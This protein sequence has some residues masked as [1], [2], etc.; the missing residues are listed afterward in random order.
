MTMY[1]VLKLFDNMIISVSVVLFSACYQK[2]VV[3]CT[4]IINRF[5]FYCYNFKPLVLFYG[6]EK[7]LT[8]LYNP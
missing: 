1:P 6:N 2:L 5:K 7:F 8:V 4:A 3:C